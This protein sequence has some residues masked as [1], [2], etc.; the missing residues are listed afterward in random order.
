M[1]LPD[2]PSH[3][4]WREFRW[5]TVTELVRLL[6]AEVHA[7]GKTATAAVFPTPQL[8]RMLVRQAW[9][10]WP[11][12]AVFPMLYHRFYEQDVGWIGRST[13]EGVAALPRD[14]SLFSGLYL[15]DLSPDEL[16]RAVR[17]ALS[18]GAAGVSLFELGGL[19]DAH[20]A[21]LGEARNLEVRT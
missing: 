16:E 19:S 1:T 9:D 7:H 4:A 14:R 5:R 11:V 21:T 6:T 3:R 10:R 15:P 2:P 12:D 18:A 17:N 13:R 8:A 20:L